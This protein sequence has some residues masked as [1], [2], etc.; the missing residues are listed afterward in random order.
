MYTKSSKT[1]LPYNRF[2]F[3]L[4]IPFSIIRE[5]YCSSKKLDGIILIFFLSSFNSIESLMLTD[6]LDLE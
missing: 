4:K 2:L 1:E 3:L 5:R 6:I